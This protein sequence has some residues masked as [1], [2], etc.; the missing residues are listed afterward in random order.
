VECKTDNHFYRVDISG[1]GTY[2]VDR[3]GANICAYGSE[4]EDALIEGML[5]PPLF[6]KLG[7]HNVWCLHASAIRIDDKAILF[8]G[9]SGIG[10]STLADFAER[11]RAKE[12]IRIADDILPLTTHQSG[13]VA[14]PRFPQLKLSDNNQYVQ[15]PDKIPLAGLYLLQ[16]PSPNCHRVYVRDVD[17]R[18][19]MLSVIDHTLA[20]CLFDRELLENQLEFASMLAATIPVRRLSFPRNRTVLTAV[21]ERILMSGR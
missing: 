8:L 15:G 5:G 2:W 9:K 3:H 17:P 18:S 10:K 20:S 7:L 14:C 6:L 11:Y 21:M 12:I 13:V 16:E 4:D 19:A 1:M